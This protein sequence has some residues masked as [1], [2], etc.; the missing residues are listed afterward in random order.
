MD[1]AAPLRV[2]ATTVH[3][4]MRLLLEKNLTTTSTQGDMTE[5][6]MWRNVQTTGQALPA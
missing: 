3:H 2:W 5:I 4:S 1:Y 6:H